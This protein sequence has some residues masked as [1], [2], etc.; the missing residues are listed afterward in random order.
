MATTVTQTGNGSTAWT[1]LSTATSGVLLTTSGAF[2]AG[3]S[4]MLQVSDDNGTSIGNA[5]AQGV[6]LNPSGYYV[7]SIPS[8]WYFRLTLSGALASTAIRASLG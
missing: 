7:T 6:K 4:V 5:F 1:L 2:P 3:A 8:G